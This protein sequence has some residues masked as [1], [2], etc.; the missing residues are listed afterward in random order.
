MKTCEEE[1]EEGSEKMMTLQKERG[2]ESGGGDMV[3]RPAGSWNRDLSLNR[4]LL[5]S[6]G[7]KMPCMT[8]Q[9][10]QKSGPPLLGQMF[11]II[12]RI[13]VKSL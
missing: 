10:Q 5:D 2:N 8:L 9:G 12:L 7:V 13:D 1:E 3:M 11:Y 4:F 6:F